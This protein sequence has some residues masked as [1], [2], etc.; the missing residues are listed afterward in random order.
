M[1]KFLKNPYAYYKES[2]ARPAAATPTVLL[3]KKG[4][5]GPQDVGILAV[6]DFRILSSRPETPG[7]YL[8][9]FF[10]KRHG[11]WTKSRTSAMTIRTGTRDSKV[12]DVDV[13][14]IPASKLVVLT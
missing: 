14:K 10:L 7:L 5:S 1:A 2:R 13:L 9:C 8:R 3:S 11:S 4:R 6:L 12:Q